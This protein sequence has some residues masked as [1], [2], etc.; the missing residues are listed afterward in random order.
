VVIADSI[1]HG[2]TGKILKTELRK[3]Y[4]GPPA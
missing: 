3:L 1:T 4:A 2:S